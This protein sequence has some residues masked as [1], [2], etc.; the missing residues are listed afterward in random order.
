MSGGRDDGVNHNLSSEFTYDCSRDIID[1]SAY[2][3]P[4]A[5]LLAMQRRSAR[6]D[7]VGTQT[8]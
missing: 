1:A 4:A 8:S 6:D 3:C 7:G 2:P 5:H